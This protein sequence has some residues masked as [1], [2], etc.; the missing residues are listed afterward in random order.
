M[1]RGV[2]YLPS[3]ATLPLMLVGQDGDG[4]RLAADGHKALGV[5]LIHRHALHAARPWRLLLLSLGGQLD[6]APVA[7]FMSRTGKTP[8]CTSR[9]LHRSAVHLYPKPPIRLAQR[10]VGWLRIMLP[11][12]HGNAHSC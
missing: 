3:P 9:P 6:W 4:A 10:S 5:H 12:M 8:C 1:F 7:L 11:L 2:P